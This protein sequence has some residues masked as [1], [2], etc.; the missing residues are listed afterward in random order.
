MEWIAINPELKTK[1]DFDEF[2][3]LQAVSSRNG[4]ALL[5][6]VSPT[7]V[8]R[9]DGSKGTAGIAI[10]NRVEAVKITALDFTDKGD[11]AL[12]IEAATAVGEIDEAVMKLYELA[13]SGEL[14]VVCTVYRKS[15]LSDKTWTKAGSQTVRVGGGE[16][17]V[18]VSNPAAGNAG[19]Y[20]IEIEKK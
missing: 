19:F 2:P 9:I 18:T 1:L 13:Q 3:A 15:A 14:D 17:T 7:S 20:K 12:T 5:A 8:H 11:V 4:L 6:G 10:D 16:V